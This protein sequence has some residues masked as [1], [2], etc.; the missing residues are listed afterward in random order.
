M[1]E[2]YNVFG[3]YLLLKKK[4]ERILQIKAATSVQKFIRR[5]Q[6]R[7][8]I[9][10]RRVTARKQWATFVI[11]TKL[12]GKTIG[13]ETSRAIDNGG[14]LVDKIWER[15]HCKAPGKFAL[16][17]PSY[18]TINSNHMSPLI[19]IEN[20]KKKTHDVYFNS[21]SSGSS[22]IMGEKHSLIDKSK[23]SFSTPL[24]MSDNLFHRF[25]D[26][27]I[28]NGS[29]EIFKDD[30]L[31]LPLRK[32]TCS[33]YVNRSMPHLRPNRRNNK[34]KK[35][36]KKIKIAR[37]SKKVLSPLIQ[38]NHQYF[39]NQILQPSDLMDNHINYTVQKPMPKYTLGELKG[40][41]NLIAKRQR[42]VANRH[43]LFHKHG[44]NKRRLKHGTLQL[45]HLLL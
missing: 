9:E 43:D 27:A 28:I 21:S 1:Q 4:K 26:N 8:N 12:A 3:E 37:S 13:P 29:E 22:K 32:T 2:K 44:L 33:F 31:I 42:K 25:S 16:V 11:N 14:I 34:K 19:N 7:K 39:H 15:Y 41:R 30:S 17:N 6:A 45:D 18:N 23:H 5:H 24:I 40:M 35:Q 38:D 20:K 36:R 10:N